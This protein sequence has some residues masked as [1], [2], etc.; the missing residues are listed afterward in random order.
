MA[1]VTLGPHYDR[2]VREWVESG[3]YNNVSEVVRAGL[4]LLEDQERARDVPQPPAAQ[5]ANF[6]GG[7]GKPVEFDLRNLP[8]KLRKKLLAA[9]TGKAETGN[10]V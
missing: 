9:S 1:S 10:S 5:P 2:L 3:R 8:K 6:V 4:R 7:E